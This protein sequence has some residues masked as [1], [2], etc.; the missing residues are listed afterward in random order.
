MS[1]QPVYL[2][3]DQLNSYFLSINQSPTGPANN[4]I[5]F[6]SG[7]DDYRYTRRFSRWL[8]RDYITIK[9]KDYLSI[10]TVNDTYENPWD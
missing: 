8:D 7:T 1:Q 2:G 6:F 5:G 3:G 9:R 10:S 4:S